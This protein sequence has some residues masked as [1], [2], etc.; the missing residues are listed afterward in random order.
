MI[1][2]NFAER[3]EISF[4]GKENHYK[5]IAFTTLRCDRVS[6]NVNVE[7]M[8]FALRVCH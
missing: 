4:H 3:M 8:S 2:L 1:R 7:L 5:G 6:L